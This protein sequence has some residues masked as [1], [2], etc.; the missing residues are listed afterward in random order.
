MK[1]TDVAIGDAI[2]S[3]MKSI[4]VDSYNLQVQK[5]PELEGRATPIFVEK[6]IR[7]TE[8]TLHY[9]SDAIRVSSPKLFADY[10]LW[11]VDVMK[12]IKMPIKYLIV[13]M[14]CISEIVE[15]YF[16]VREVEIIRS[17]I[18]NG[19]DLIE[20]SEN[21]ELIETSSEHPLK[22]YRTE[23]VGY[24]LN[25]ERHKAN[26]LVQELVKLRYSVQDI[27]M[28]IFHESQ[29]EIGK[30]W[31]AN[32]ITIAEEHY[33]T[34]S[35]QLIMGQLYPL[36]FETPKND[37]VF[38]GASVGGEL[39]ELGVRMVSDFMELAGWN[40]YYLG[41]NMPAKSIVETLIKEKANILGLSVTM[42]FHIKEASD[43]IMAIKLDPQCAELKIVVGGYP[44]IV[45]DQLWMT[46][47]A[48]GFALNAREAVEIAESLVGSGGAR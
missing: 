22:K 27:Y 14:E 31:Q 42:S 41:A 30:L 15:K 28:E 6:S 9:L 8:Y 16:N 7:D 45:D 3:K 36:I 18:K 21:K 12:N 39:H 11:F 32:K 48:D 29:Y 25:A 10:V 26:A 35:T 13:N 1:F 4:A 44:F 20:M 24:L 47:G 33:C 19:L 5:M 46:I 43:L 17:Y 40:T 38:V 23:Y 37:L 34:A 2:K